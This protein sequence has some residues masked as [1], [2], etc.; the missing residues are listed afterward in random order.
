MLLDFY[1]IENFFYG[2]NRITLSKLDDPIREVTYRSK[3][4]TTHIVEKCFDVN[5][6]S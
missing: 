6:F 1:F 3:E 5:N 2:K 4:S